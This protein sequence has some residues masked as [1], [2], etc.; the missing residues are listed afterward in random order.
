MS[1]ESLIKRAMIE[2]AS[3]PK[4]I[5][6]SRCHRA[7]RRRV[8]GLSGQNR[9]HQG[10]PRPAIPLFGLRGAPRED[11]GAMDGRQKENYDLRLAG[12]D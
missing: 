3:W 2:D 9:P 8:P 5:A 10:A 1:F 11:L 4:K 6:R 12:R 7:V